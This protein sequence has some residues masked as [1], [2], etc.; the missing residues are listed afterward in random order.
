MAF[1]VCHDPELCVLCCLSTQ[2]ERLFKH[3]PDLL[4]EFTYFLP[5]AQAVKDQQQRRGGAGSNYRG[6]GTNRPLGGRGAH[7]Q[8]TSPVLKHKRKT[9]QRAEEGFKAGCEWLY[10]GYI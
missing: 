2:V 9:A 7:L 6:S 5:D 10:I 3:E 8:N 4:E 1:D